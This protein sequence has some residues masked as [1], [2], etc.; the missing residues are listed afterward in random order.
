MEPH[1]GH[2]PKNY[3]VHLGLII[4]EGDC[5]MS[6]DGETRRWQSGKVTMFDD[7]Y[8]RAAWNRTTANR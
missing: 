5:G 8:I 2:D 4:P 3:R 7:T 1:V 6:V